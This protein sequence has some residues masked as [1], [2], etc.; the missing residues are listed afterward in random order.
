MSKHLYCML[1]NGELIP[2][3]KVDETLNLLIKLSE[4]FSVVQ[5]TDEE[6]FQNGYTFD[7]VMRFREK[8]GTTVREAKDAIDFLRGREID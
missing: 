1:G 5:L 2:K 4:G 8:Y 3:R 7:A 6:L